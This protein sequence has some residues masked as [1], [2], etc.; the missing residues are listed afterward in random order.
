MGS[1]SANEKE[2]LE[3]AFRMN[4]EEGLERAFL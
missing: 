3:E 1:T 4:K 2:E